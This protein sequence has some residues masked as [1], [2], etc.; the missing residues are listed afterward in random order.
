MDHMYIR[1]NT[2]KIDIF[3]MTAINHISRPSE[4]PSNFTSIKENRRL[5]IVEPDFKVGLRNF[6][7]SE[8]NTEKLPGNFTITMLRLIPWLLVGSLLMVS[9]FL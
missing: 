3:A 2:I 1:N 9:I 8:R 6:K 5:K 4:Q 7:Y